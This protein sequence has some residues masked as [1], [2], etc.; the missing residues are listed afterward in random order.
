[1]NFDFLISLFFPPQCLRC[2]RGLERGALCGEC[3]ERIPIAQS[4]FC[5]ACRRPLTAVTDAA[6]TAADLP[7]DH[8][9]RTGKSPC[10][11][12]FPYLLGAAS[13]YHDRTITALVRALKFHR[14]RAAAE[15]LAL[16]IAEY[17]SSI[18]SA[19]AGHL[20]IPIPLSEKRR[21][22][23]GFNQAELIAEQLAERFSLPLDRGSLARTKNTPPQS[24]TSSLAER[25]A[26]MRG[27]FSVQNPATIA[28][29][30]I[31]LVDDVVTSGA[32]FLEAARALREAG[33]E[34][35]VALAAAQG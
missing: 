10:H 7:G 28:D 20:I 21:R 9:L 16:I 11:P 13:R 3:Q 24:E 14:I 35:V 26:H 27:C 8:F 15:P 6:G 18:S 2:A 31:L 17:I 22:E 32:T 5:G 34:T 1:M 19:T 33:A 25:M 29:K 30:R 12:E 4:F 23:R